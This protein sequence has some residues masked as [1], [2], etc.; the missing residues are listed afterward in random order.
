[1]GDDRV[2]RRDFVR[3]TGL[4][5]TG[6]A[7]SMAAARTVYAGNPAGAETSKILNY[8]SQMEY[9]RCGRTEMMISAV[10]LG[11]HWKRIDTVVPKVSSFDQN[12]TEVVSRCIDRGINY[13][14]ACVSGEVLAYSKALKGRRDKMH[15]GYS[16]C[17]KEARSGVWRSFPKLKESF[18]E[19]LKAAGLDYV[20]LWRITC[21]EH[22]SNHTDAEMEDIVKAL[23]WAQKSGRARFTG[24]SSHDRPHIKRLDRKVSRAPGS[25][26]H[27]LYGQDQAG[28]GRERTLVGDEEAGRGLVRH[29]A[30][31]QQLAVQ[32]DQRPRQS[33]LRGRQ[34]H[35]PAGSAATFSATRRLLPRS[36]G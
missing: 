18:D 3:D 23:D 8:N 28:R 32:G 27:A 13:I 12:R 16:W 22:S 29:Q 25:D 34:P 21:Y 1:M 20:D 11:G 33:A 30:L 4:L 19:G 10:C 9:R 5:A 2:T 36:P 26:L 7:L 14:D 35:R 15:L 17:E 31:R 24:I 6:V